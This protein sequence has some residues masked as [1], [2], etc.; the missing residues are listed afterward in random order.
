MHS[1]GALGRCKVPRAGSEQ[2][3]VGRRPVGEVTSLLL[4]TKTS[5]HSSSSFTERTAMVLVP[6]QLMG[7]DV[8]RSSLTSLKRRSRETRR[9]VW[10]THV[11]MANWVFI[12]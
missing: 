3:T 12:T 9:E 10:E 11:R 7:S 4:L 2:C 8:L 1:A 5:S 6:W